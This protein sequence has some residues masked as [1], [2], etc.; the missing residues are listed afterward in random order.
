LSK[1]GIRLAYSLTTL[2]EELLFAAGKKQPILRKSGSNIVIKYHIVIKP[3]RI[4]S[5]RDGDSYHV[6]IWDVLKN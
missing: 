4:E 5:G 1:V 2:S 3:A 6:I